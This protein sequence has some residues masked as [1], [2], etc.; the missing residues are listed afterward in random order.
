[1]NIQAKIRMQEN[2]SGGYSATQ[3]LQEVSEAT[4]QIRRH[5]T[6]KYSSEF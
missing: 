6:E 3:T 5:M 2:F 1:M 4:A